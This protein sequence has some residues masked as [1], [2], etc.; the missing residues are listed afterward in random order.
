MNAIAPTFPQEFL[1]ENPALIVGL[2][3]QES[4]RLVLAEVSDDGP[5][6]TVL[7]HH[8]FRSLEGLHRYLRPSILGRIRVVTVQ[9]DHGDPFGVRAWLSTHNL[10]IHHYHNPG[11][12]GHILQ[13]QDQLEFWELPRSY[14]LAYTLAFLSSYRLHSEKTV[15]KLWRQTCLMK[16]ILDEYDREL[17]RLSH[18]LGKDGIRPTLQQWLCP[19]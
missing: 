9:A 8:C 1:N 3:I 13:L 14:E 11:W 17:A 5:E 4:L 7:A 16:E 15:H 18:S 2:D 6:P 19:F 12:S 10:T